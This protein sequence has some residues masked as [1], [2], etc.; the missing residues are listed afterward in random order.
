MRALLLAAALLAAA[1]AAR[2]GQPCE[3]QPLEVRD[4][5]QAM[6][7]AA[8]TAARLDAS[9]AR[10]VV[11]ARVGQDLS[12]HGL[13]YSHLRFAYREHDGAPWRV[14]HKLNHCGTAQAALYRHGLGDFFLDRLHR[15]EAG[16][17]VLAPGVQQRL[18]PLLRDNRR[19]AQWHV[20]RYSMVAYPWAQTYQQSNQ[21][22]IETLAGAMEPAA[23]TR[24]QAQAWLQLRDYRPT[25][26]RLGPLTR[27]GARATA[28]HV[29]FDDHPGEKR[30]AD[31]IE[32]VTVES[33]FQWLARTGLGDVP[34]TVH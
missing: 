8:R 14:L 16:V 20:A 4:V 10:V 32:T 1:G 22:A 19:A 11:V 31:R 30:F 13:H 3:A 5:E 25:V 2:A 7:L 9:G 18:L 24:R 27:L 21:W 12:R 29:A 17:V 26:L 33:V 34:F 15:Y 28:A 23:A 6:E